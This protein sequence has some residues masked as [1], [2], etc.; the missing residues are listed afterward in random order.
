V[1]WKFA[2]LWRVHWKDHIFSAQIW[3]RKKERRKG[4]K[5]SLKDLD[6][7][8]DKVV[9]YLGGSLWYSMWI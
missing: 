5:V 7:R 2:L 9:V 3:K 6:G 4:E 1:R 8:R